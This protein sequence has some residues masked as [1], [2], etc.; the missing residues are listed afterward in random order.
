MIKILLVGPFLND[1]AGGITIHVKNLIEIFKNIE[2]INI[3]HFAITDAKHD[4]EPWAKKIKRLINRLVPFVI[5]ARSCDVIHLNSTFDN[6]SVLRDLFYGAIVKIIRRK[7]VIIQFHGGRPSNV[8][9]FTNKLTRFLFGFLFGHF[10]HVLALSKFQRSQFISY[11]PNID[12]RLVPNCVQLNLEKQSLP[13]RHQVVFLFIGRVAESKG[14]LKIIR[15]AKILVNDTLDFKI[16]ICGTGPLQE[17][18]LKEIYSNKLQDHI[19]YLGFVSG[20]VKEK[21][22]FESD[23]MLL[24]TDHDEGFPY[25]LLEAFSYGLPVIGTKKGAI[26]EVIEDGIDGFVMNSNHEEIL[27]EKMKY[28]CE[29][30]GQAARM[31][32]FGKEKLIQKYN[33][34][35]LLEKLINIY[36]F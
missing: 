3:E 5:I 19:Q 20:L 1:I 12:V 16:I 34:N 22:F 25:S 14:I 33:C 21:I 17:Q 36:L 2:D 9:F 15:A 8:F 11:F 26:P 32:K 28:F 24:P 6:R 4:Q 31:G 23:V 35:I 10:N 30:Q 29:H 7:K 18:L 13:D 27:Y